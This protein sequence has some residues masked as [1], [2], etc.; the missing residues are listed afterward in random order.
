MRAVIEGLQA[1]PGIPLV[2]SVTIVA[3]VG[4]LSRFATPYVFACSSDCCASFAGVAVL[5][6]VW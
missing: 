6:K 4:E 2:S 3:E 1:L 5:E